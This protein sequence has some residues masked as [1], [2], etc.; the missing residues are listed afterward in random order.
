MREIRQQDVDDI[1]TGA[2]FMGA[3]GGGDPYVGKLM[4]KVVIG[5]GQP[6]KLISV[7]E[8]DPDAIYAPVACMGAPSVMTE[9]FPKG[10][11]FQRVLEA[12][13]E[14]RHKKIGGIFPI[15]AGG[16]NSMIPLV[17]G[18]QT[19]I[20]V[21]DVDSMGR[22]FPELQMTT[23]HLAGVTV[24]PMAITDEKGNIGLLET[25]TDKWAEL[26][27][28]DMTVELG[29]TAVVSL[30]STTGKMLQEVGVHGI[31]T[32]CQR[33]GQIVRQ[34]SRG[35]QWQLNQIHQLTGSFHLFDG[36]VVDVSQT[37]S[38]GFNHGQITVDGLKEFTGHQLVIDYQN[39]NLI[40]KLDG[41]V[42]TSVPDLICLADI[43]SLTPFT[44]EDV[45]Y[46]KRLSVFGLPCDPQWRTAKG[47]AT[48]GPRYFGYDYDYVPVEQL[49]KEGR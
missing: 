7:D 15:E 25:V 10:D 14:R 6:V 34:R 45:R 40:A 16:V 26:L 2:S 11:E 46:G 21:V 47:L 29:A 19:G 38:G 22:A 35:R 49:V 27:A 36:K 4:A 23:L 24:P 18:A 30:F 32:K 20:P 13:A 33:L 31:L 5:K 3:G 1:A 28:R 8:L 44:A 39:E 9:K 17:L 37:T 48:V 12:V 43:N 41:Q 42:V